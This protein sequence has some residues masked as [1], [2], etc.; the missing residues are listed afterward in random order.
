MPTDTPLPPHGEGPA[1]TIWLNRMT[2]EIIKV[3]TLTK[4]GAFVLFSSA[5]DQADIEALARPRFNDCGIPLYVQH[6][7]D[8]AS[9]LIAQFRA[10]NGNVLFGLK[11]LWEG[12]DIPGDT[13]R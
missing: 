10:T 2:D 8:N 3:C 11:T 6:S 12:I 13:L 5:K 4:G 9:Q 7:G 1:R